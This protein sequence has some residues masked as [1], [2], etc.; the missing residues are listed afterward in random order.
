MGKTWKLKCFLFHCCSVPW[1]GLLISLVKCQNF[2]FN[3]CVFPVIDAFICI[4]T[5]KMSACYFLPYTVRWH[6]GWAV[7]LFV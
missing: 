5:T 2:C 3:Q 7:Y 4:F 1:K 6:V